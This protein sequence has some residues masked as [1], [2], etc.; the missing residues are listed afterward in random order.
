M[1]SFATAKEAGA[2]ALITTAKDAVKL[3]T[4]VVF[5]SVLCAGD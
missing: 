3:R 4:L 2:T 1:R 5:D